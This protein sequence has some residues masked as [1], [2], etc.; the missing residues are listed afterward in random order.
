RDR[1]PR[2][3][4]ASL[5]GTLRLRLGHRAT[6]V[7]VRPDEPCSPIHRQRTLRRDPA[8]RRPDLLLDQTAHRVGVARTLLTRPVGARA[9]AGL[10]DTRFTVLWVVPHNAAAPRLVPTCS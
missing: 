6:E 2:P 8:V 4:D 1:N 10:L 7:A 3:I 5:T 9:G